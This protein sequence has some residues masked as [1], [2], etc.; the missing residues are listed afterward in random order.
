[1]GQYIPM[2]SKA[3]CGQALAGAA[4]DDGRPV[5][6]RTSPTTARARRP[7]RPTRAASWRRTASS[8]TTPAPTKSAATRKAMMGDIDALI[9]DAKLSPEIVKLVQGRRRLVVPESAPSLNPRDTFWDRVERTLVGL[10]GAIAMMVGVVQVVGRYFFP[11][12]AIS[13]GRGGDRLPRRLGRDDHLEPARA[14]RRP[15]PARPGAAP[16]R[17]DRASAGWKPSTASWRW[18]SASAW[19]GTASSIVESSW[20]LDEHSSTD[21]AFPMWI[22]YS[23]LP[24]GGLLM[25]RALLHPALPL[26]V[27]LRSRD[28]DR[29]P[30]RRA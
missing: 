26:P 12:Y 28:H 8:S 27:P 15:C 17:H 29:R 24:V 2:M 1:M 30:H 21:F 5:G 19:C 6:R 11:A 14:H 20:M 23:A 25:T 9:K 18:S 3:F 22:Y 7:A 16:G 13:L 10:L 4:E